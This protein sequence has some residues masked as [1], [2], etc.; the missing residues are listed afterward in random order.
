MR[1]IDRS[2][3]IRVET[4]EVRFLDLSGDG[5]PDAVER[6]TR[7][8]RRDPGNRRVEVVEES[9]QLEYGIGVDGEPAGVVARS[10]VYRPDRLGRLRVVHEEPMAA[11]SA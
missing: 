11:Q 4:R 2:G 1:V 9:R 8:A 3:P 6:I 5:V 10:L 7:C